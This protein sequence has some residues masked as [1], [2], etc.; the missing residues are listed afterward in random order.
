MNWFSF[1]FCPISLSLYAHLYARIGPFAKHFELIFSHYFVQ[2]FWRIASNFPKVE[3]C[4]RVH[5]ECVVKIDKTILAYAHNSWIIKK[6]TDRKIRT[7]TKTWTIFI[8]FF[9]IKMFTKSKSVYFLHVKITKHTC[10]IAH[11]TCN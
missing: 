2:H 5:I 9:S 4:I 3:N 6:N 7:N 10:T 1:F 11:T 8:D